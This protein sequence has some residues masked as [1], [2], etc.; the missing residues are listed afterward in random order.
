L[1]VLAEIAPVAAGIALAASSFPPSSPPPPPPPS[2]APTGFVTVPTVRPGLPPPV[3]RP[4]AQPPAGQSGPGAVAVTDPAVT[5]P[6]LVVALHNTAAEATATTGVMGVAGYGLLGLNALPALSYV[7]T[8]YSL[9]PGIT[10]DAALVTLQGQFPNAI[11]APNNLYSL[12]AGAA[13]N[14]AAGEISWKTAAPSCGANIRIGMIDTQVDASI[15]ALKTRSVRARS[16]VDD[17]RPPTNHGTQV[18]TILVGA[19]SRGSVSGLMP[20]GSLYS[21][22]VFE[23]MANGALRASTPALAR[24]MD[25]LVGESVSVINLSFAGPMNFALLGIVQRASERNVLLVGAA[26]NEG[27]ASPPLYPAA[28]PKV[29]AV[30]AVDA[31]RHPYQYNVIGKH[32][33]F[34]APG[35]NLPLPV[36][37]AGGKVDLISGT[38][39]ASPYAAA[40]VALWRQKRTDGGQAEAITELGARAIRLAALTPDPVVGYG[41]IQS[42][43]PCS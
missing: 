2:R 28:F 37:E 20:S 21:A 12:A 9:P 23:H 19:T 30:T 16:F 35:V 29:I 7:M 4:P 15:A 6:N 43:G 25:W 27:P 3:I 10:L 13:F 1:G 26:G 33:A 24:A 32:I 39:F 18:A 42:P 17:P 11:F 41:L 36:A 34:T 8:V 22:G 31:N 14:N 5:V 40:V 38:S